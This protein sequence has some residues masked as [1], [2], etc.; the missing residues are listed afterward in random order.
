MAVAVGYAAWAAEPTRIRRPARRQ[1]PTELRAL[2]KV[3]CA[4]ARVVLCSIAASTVTSGEN[5]A[6]ILEGDVRIDITPP[7]GARHINQSASDA[8]RGAACRERRANRGMTVKA[9][10]V[11]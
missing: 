7:E 3:S 11:V 4:S 6:Q 8:R 1:A 5:G 9:Q 10:K 2:G